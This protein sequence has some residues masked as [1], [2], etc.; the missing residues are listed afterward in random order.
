MRLEPAGAEM[1]AAL[2]EV[3]AASF[4]A[5]WSAADVAELLASPGGYAL[6]ALDD[7]GTVQGF[8]LARAIA[9]EAEILTLAVR[10]AARRRGIALAL[11]ESAA[12][13]G[14]SHGAEGLFLEVAA[15][16]VAAIGLYTSAGF[17]QVGRRRGYYANPSGPAID[18]LIMRRDLNSAHT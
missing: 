14:A 17:S 9:G 4:T 12:R 6:A 18:A 13:L 10:P 11:V 2:A 1:A 7:S 5:A 16:N 3:H 8:I 15:D